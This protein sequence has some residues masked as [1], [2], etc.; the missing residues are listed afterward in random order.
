MVAVVT[1]TGSSCEVARKIVL[2]LIRK[3]GATGV[4]GSRSNPVVKV[5]ESGGSFVCHIRD[6][7]AS[8]YS[9]ACDRGHAVVDA[10]VSSHETEQ[11]RK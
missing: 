3:I 8:W 2:K 7:T 5:T 6:A 9:A 10:K 11:R 1:E 4:H